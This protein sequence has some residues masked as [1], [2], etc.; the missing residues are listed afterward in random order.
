M[1]NSYYSKAIKFAKPPVKLI[2]WTTETGK[3]KPCAG[4][5][6]VTVLLSTV[7]TVIEGN[8]S[9]ANVKIEPSAIGA[10]KLLTKSNVVESAY[11][12]VTFPTSTPSSYTFGPEPVIKLLV[13][14]PI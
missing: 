2:T 12:A 14:N 8:A 3:T 6:N 5:V 1:E 11:T 9:K 7:R 10:A 13:V 4:F